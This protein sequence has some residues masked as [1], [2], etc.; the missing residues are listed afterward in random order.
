MKRP[1]H[2]ADFVDPPLDEV[3]LGVQFAPVPAYASVHSWNVWNL[4]K[5][6]FPK[7][8]EQPILPPQFETF[9]GTNVQPGLQFQF[10]SAPV[11]SRLWFISNDENHL[12]QFQHDRFLTNWRRR[13]NSLPYPRFEG[14]AEA[15]ERNLTT[16][17][18]FFSQEFACQLDV[19]QAE[20]S[21]INVIPVEDFAEAGDWFS[22]WNGRHLKPEALN[23]SFN[24]VVV[25]ND[26]NPF[27]RMKHEI[28]S[29]VRGE[30]MSKAFS[31]SLNYQGKPSENSIDSAMEFLRA[32]REE[33]VTRFEDLT[34]SKA[35]QIWGK[36]G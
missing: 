20:V 27:A 33:I 2:L 6:E 14:I 26:G 22:L 7:I 4:F 21:Y 3:V 13:H 31:L 23:T 8:R 28:Q 15:F 29:I 34:T 1:Q 17:S 36:Q 5:E 32:G 11:G 12:I 9:G 25:D 30:N 16:L 18:N 35:H 19:N 10:G 24:E